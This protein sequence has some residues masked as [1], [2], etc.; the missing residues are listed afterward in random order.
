MYDEDVEKAILY[1]M[2]FE[3]EDFAICEDD[4]MV[5]RN[6]KIAKAILELKKERKD[7]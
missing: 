4:F 5:D 7:I 2:I 3:N 6:K 1:Y